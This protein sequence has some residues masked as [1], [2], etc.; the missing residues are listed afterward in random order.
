MKG[1][2]TSI[3]SQDEDFLR[4]KKNDILGEFWLSLKDETSS[5]EIQVKNDLELC[6]KR[7]NNFQSFEKF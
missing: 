4:R 6:L 2:L 3:E 1:L 5:H 7:I